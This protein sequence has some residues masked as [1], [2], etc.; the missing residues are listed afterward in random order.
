MCRTLGSASL[1][2]KLGKFRI[3]VGSILVRRS[4]WPAQ[5]GESA[6]DT[7]W[8]GIRVFDGCTSSS[9]ISEQIGKQLKTAATERELL[10]HNDIL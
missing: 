8:F 5:V 7:I 2:V 1:A 6:A 9:P 3:S 4:F 10:L